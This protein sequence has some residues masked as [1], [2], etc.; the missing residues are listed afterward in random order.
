MHIN[1]VFH[2]NDAN[3]LLSTNQIAEI[4]QVLREDFFWSTFNTTQHLIL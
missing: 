1:N 4:S 2:F 3:T